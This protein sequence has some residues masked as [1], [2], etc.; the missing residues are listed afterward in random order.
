VKKREGKAKNKALLA[1][2]ITEEEREKFNQ[3]LK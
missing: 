2:G 3:L 1:A